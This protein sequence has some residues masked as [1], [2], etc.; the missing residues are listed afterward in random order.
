MTPTAADDGDPDDPEQER[1]GRGADGGYTSTTRIFALGSQLGLIGTTTLLGVVLARI[2]S[3]GDLGLWFVLMSASTVA[4][5]IMLGGAPPVL[6]RR[7][8]PGNYDPRTVLRSAVRISSMCSAVA[9]VLLLWPVGPLLAANISGR[10]GQTFVYLLVLLTIAQAVQRFMAE[11]FRGLHRIRAAVSLNGVFARALT[12]LVF[13]VY[14]FTSTSSTLTTVVVTQVVA[15]GLVV[16]VIVLWRRRVFTAPSTTGGD[17]GSFTFVSTWPLLVTNVLGL[18]VAQGDLVIAAVLLDATDVALYGVALRVAAFILIPL[19]VV[20]SLA[21]PMMAR[22]LHRSTGR[23]QAQ[24][25]RLARPSGA[26]AIV[27][28]AGIIVLGRFGLRIGFG[29]EYVDAFPV[30]V[31]L[32]AGQT[33]NTITGPCNNLLIAAGYDRLVVHHALAGVVVMIGAGSALGIAFGM[34]GLAVGSACA[35]IV[36]NILNWQSARSLIGVRTDMLAMPAR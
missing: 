17:D 34:M 10:P 2:L 26:A 32:G 22:Q 30:V 24:V 3:P 29:A 5:G 18:I 13:A 1:G 19:Y 12:V 31:V 14:A 9:L 11:S 23:L 33:L 21:P 16:G 28:L 15:V 27:I 7:L 20:N 25:T 4:H 6:V 8:A 35:T 36:Q